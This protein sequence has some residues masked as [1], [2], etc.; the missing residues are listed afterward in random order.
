[1]KMVIELGKFEDNSAVKLT[2]DVNFKAEIID[3]ILST[4]QL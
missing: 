3:G 4:I 2:F 1:M